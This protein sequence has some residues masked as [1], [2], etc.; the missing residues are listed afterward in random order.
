M[1]IGTKEQLLN[2]AGNRG[3]SPSDKTCSRTRRVGGLLKFEPEL[4]A[5]R[6]ADEMVVLRALFVGSRIW[7]VRLR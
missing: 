7:I 2:R 1:R 4:G 3:E 6:A 5:I